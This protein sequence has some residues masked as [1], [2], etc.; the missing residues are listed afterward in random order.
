MR[1]YLNVIMN[2]L[3][4]GNEDQSFL[5]ARW[6][7]KLLK[8]A[9]EKYKRRLAL[10]ALSWSPHYFFRNSSPEYLHLSHPEFTEK[11]FERNRLG[12]GKLCSQVLL[13]HLNNTQVVLDYGCGPG[14][15]ANSVSKHVRTLYAVDLSRG[16][17]E[18]ARI[19]NSSPNST[20]IH[21]TQ[22][23]EIEEGSI[24]LIYS[25]AVIQHVTDAIFKM[26][27]ATM[28]EKLKKG[29]KLIIHVV[30]D[31]E[32]WR[33]EQDWRRDMTVKGRLKWKYGLNCF[34]RN[35]EDV[36]GMLV[37]AGFTSIVLQ[38]MQEL[39][40]ERFDDVCTQHLIRAVK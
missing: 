22:L 11:E 21:T 2:I 28:Y 31:E 34:K 24:D 29:G 39:C 14:F 33:M 20:F 8:R 27:L 4:L 9:P 5:G 3:T 7:E 37:S 23:R 1:K 10:T 35:E 17:L 38:P 16:V 25:F 18:C 12:R 30:I 19:L 36:K 6:I 26:I 15:L 40:P 13:S 32:N